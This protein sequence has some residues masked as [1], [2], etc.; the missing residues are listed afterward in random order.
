MKPSAVEKLRD[1][2]TENRHWNRKRE[3][4]T[5]ADFQRSES[6]LRSDD[7]CHMPEN[8]RKSSLIL[9]S[10][11]AKFQMTF[12]FIFNDVFDDVSL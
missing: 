8:P 5:G 4:F 12:C 9:S 3:C 10:F 7:C 6:S 1:P 2:R 11:K